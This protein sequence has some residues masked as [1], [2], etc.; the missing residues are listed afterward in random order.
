MDIVLQMSRFLV[1]LS[2]KAASV[3]CPRA[4]SSV[5]DIIEK[6]GTVEFLNCFLVRLTGVYVPRYIY[7]T[8]SMQKFTR[9]SLQACFS[10]GWPYI[11]S[12]RMKKHIDPR[13]EKRQ[14]NMLLSEARQ[15]VLHLCKG[16]GPQNPPSC[17]LTGR[18]QMLEH[19][20][21]PTSNYRCGTQPHPTYR[22]RASGNAASGE[23][24]AGRI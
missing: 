11:A 16:L 7:G 2:R 8:Q 23:A 9:Q 20:K 24:G 3:R 6:V 15:C 14:A 1:S 22:W 19:G 21:H 5:T 10:C 17:L 12:Q 18:G 13:L 4:D